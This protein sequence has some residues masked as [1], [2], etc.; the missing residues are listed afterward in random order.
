MI[1]V[2]NKNPFDFTDRYNGQDFRIPSGKTV[3]I[4]EEAARHFFGIGEADKTPYLVRQGWMN[5]SGQLGEAMGKLNNFAFDLVDDLIPGEIVEMDSRSETEQGSAPLQPESVVNE[6][7][8]GVDETMD[9]TSIGDE[10]DDVPAVPV[11][12]QQSGKS[13]LDKLGGVA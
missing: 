5:N 4:G 9:S 7:P 8:D 11:L 6:A 12:G 10:A 1:K 13:I 2:T 3:A